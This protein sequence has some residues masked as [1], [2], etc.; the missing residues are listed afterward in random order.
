MYRIFNSVVVP[1]V[2]CQA[3]CD[4]PGA[5]RAAA[6]GQNL[7]ACKRLK[8]GFACRV[9][10]YVAA[11]YQEIRSPALHRHRSAGTDGDSF[12]SRYFNPP[13]SLHLNWPT[14][15]TSVP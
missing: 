8:N 11:P 13:Y 5:T 10:V 9:F 7:D 6:F 1:A 12:S 15:V 4:T 3:V 2:P 14:A